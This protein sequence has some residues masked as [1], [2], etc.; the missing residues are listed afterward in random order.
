MRHKC[1][2]AQVR[3]HVSARLRYTNARLGHTVLRAQV[4]KCTFVVGTMSAHVHNC[5]SAQMHERNVDARL[6][7]SLSEPEAKFRGYINS[8]FEEMNNEL[9]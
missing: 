3:M 5:A 4:R 9:Y 6:F 7:V 2:G 1:V 8:T